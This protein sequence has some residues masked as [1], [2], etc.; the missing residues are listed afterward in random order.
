MT[1]QEYA[2]TIAKLGLTQVGAAKFLKIGDRTS[3]R[4]ISGASKIPHAV[5]LLFD[6]MIVFDVKPKDLEP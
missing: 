6:L 1:R 4:W 3:R 2:E 5:E